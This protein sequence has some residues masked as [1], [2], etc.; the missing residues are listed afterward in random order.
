[1]KT[2]AT[3]VVAA[4]DQVLGQCNALGAKYNPSNQ[5]MN[6]T[7]MTALLTSADETVKAVN[8][9]ASN[10]KQAVNQRQSD[11]EVLPSLSTRI[12][13]AL[14][15][16]QA[17]P[18]VIQDVRMLRDKFRSRAGKKK[19][20]PEESTNPDQGAVTSR[21][22]VSYLDFESKV[23]NLR[24]IIDLLAMEVRYQPNEPGLTI[25]ELSALAAALET[26]NK[27]V[28]D[29][30]TAL[31]QARTMRNSFLYG[32]DGIY[33][34]SVRV[35]KYVMSVFGARSEQFKSINRIRIMK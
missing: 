24:A 23:V 19:R 1:M 22:P 35:K 12:L 32:D 3:K 27:S 18:K 8:H 14:V 21:G 30:V 10:L 11:F 31:G 29:A 6:L 5:S 15:A 17:S 33:G 26:R 4:F 7:A 28:R 13:N 25:G 9:A 20:K 16:C 34:T 2:N